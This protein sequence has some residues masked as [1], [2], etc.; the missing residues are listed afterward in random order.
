MLLEKMTCIEK[1]DEH[2]VAA[3]PIHNIDLRLYRASSF[4]LSQNKWRDF[5]YK[6]VTYLFIFWQ[7]KIYYTKKVSLEFCVFDPVLSI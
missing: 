2:K 5:W 3:L 6:L 7:L 4:I 1:W